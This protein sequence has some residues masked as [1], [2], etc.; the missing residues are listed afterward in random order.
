MTEEERYAR[1][2]KLVEKVNQGT[3]QIMLDSRGI[4]LPAN[5]HEII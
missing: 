4:N 3:L 2:I 1:F 5:D